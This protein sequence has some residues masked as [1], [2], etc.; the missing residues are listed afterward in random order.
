MAGDGNVCVKLNMYLILCFDKLVLQPHCR[1][2]KYQCDVNSQ[3][4]F[5]STVDARAS[6]ASACERPWYTPVWLTPA[7]SNAGNLGE[8]KTCRYIRT[9]N[10]APGKLSQWAKSPRKCIYSVSAPETAKHR[11]KFG[12]LPLSE[13]A[14]VTKPKR[15]TRCNLL[16]CPKLANRSQPL[17]GQSSPYRENIRRRYC[18]L[19]SFF[20]TVDA[21]LSCEDT[22][23]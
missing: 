21:C 12:W 5:V 15:E 3:R 19:T 4:G 11:A 2:L 13:V 1:L 18:C 8:R 7:A 10:F 22:A 6:S 23:R 20:P 14:A 17:V 9:V 16:G